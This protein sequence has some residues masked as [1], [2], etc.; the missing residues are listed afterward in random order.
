MTEA[1]NGSEQ[2]MSLLPSGI[3]G[4]DTILKGG[5]LRGG[6]YLVQ[7]EP[8]SG[9]TILGNQLCFNH[10]ASGG[11]ALFVTL[12]TE[13]HARMLLHHRRLAFFD[14][15]I[16]PTSLSY[17]SAF[18]A[19]EEE[20]LPGLLQ[21]LRREV[22]RC[23]V[24]VLVLDGFVAARESAT[25][26]LELKKFIHGLQTQATLADCTIFLLSSHVV[27]PPPP[28]HTMIDG[29]VELASHLFGRRAERTLE[30]VK[31]RGLGFLRGQ[32]SVRITDAGLTV[33]PR[34]EALLGK[35][36]RED[37]VDGPTLSTCIP[38]LDSMLGGGLLHCSTTMLVGPSG[39]GKTITGLQFLGGASEQQPGLFFGFFET[40]AR[41][42]AKAKHL[43]LPVEHRI[44][45]GHVEIIWQP[46]TE[47]VLDEVGNRL[48]EAVLRRKVRR[49]FLDGR[50]GLEKLALEPER[51]VRFMTALSNELR[52]LGVT[53]LFTD[54]AELLGPGELPVGGLALREASGISDNLVVMRFVELRTRLERVISVLKVRD[55]DFQH[56]LRGF[57][58]TIGGIAVDKDSERAEALLAEALGQ[59]V[60]EV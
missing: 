44:A 17:I 52:G 3:A 19:L 28:E 49:L 11:R 24:S 6:I 43:N 2:E 40:P 53:T 41:L 1:H 25:S 50:I 23:G 35:P 26:E 29:V 22:Q 57:T 31:R 21:L 38:E 10:A 20:G 46:I 32:H 13:T 18:R 55:G 45:E 60:R 47:G 5:F 36:T 4:L 9:K 48:L 30:I 14:E 16:V 51:I 39:C 8:G 58:I 34:I 42:H 37:P 12:L 15:S 56:R 27:R 54:E 59:R 7:G 33:F